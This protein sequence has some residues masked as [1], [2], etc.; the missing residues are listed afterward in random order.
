M[1]ARKLVAALLGAAALLPGARAAPP[2][3]EAFA[4]VPSMSGV[5]ISPDG[6]RIAYLRPVN[7]LPAAFVYDFDSKAPPVAV[8]ASDPTLA[9]IAW[10]RF[11][12]DTV[13]VCGYHGTVRSLDGPFPA[14]RLVAVNLADRKMKVLI[15]RN[16]DVGSSQFQDEILDW[17]AGDPTRVL[18]ALR[19]QFDEHPGVYDLDV[20]TGVLHLRLQPY[21]P[22]DEFT[23]DATGEVRLGCGVRDTSMQCFTRDPADGAWRLLVKYEYFLGEG[24]RLAK[25]LGFGTD[26]NILYTLGEF[27]GHD[28]LWRVDLRDRE[29]PQ[30][31]FTHPLV[32][33]EGTIRTRSGRL[34]G[35]RY[36]TDRPNVYYLDDAYRDEMRAVAALV[37]DHA[38]EV[39]SASADEARHI[40]L[41]RSD[42]DAGSYYLYDRGKHTLLALGREYPELEPQQL[43]RMQW[44]EYA[45][46]D[47]T[48]IPGY[49][50][51]PRGAPAK[52]L[53]LIVM[54]HGGPI[55]RDRWRFFFLQ[56]FLVSRGYAVLQ[57]NFRGSAGYGSAWFAAAHQDWGGL[58]YRDIEDGARWAVSSGVADPGR[59]AVVGW[60]FGGYAAL[61]AAVR[62]G[63]SYRGAISI[64]G[65]SDLSELREEQHRFMNYRIADRQIGDDRA[66]LKAD[67]P[68][69]HAADAATPVLLIHGTRDWQ[70][71]VDHSKRM[72]S[73]LKS[74][75]K[76][77]E[78]ILLEGE[79]HQIDGEAARAALLKAVERFLLEH[80]GPGVSPPT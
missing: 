65:V 27:E 57:M 26:P 69:R 38:V 1:M 59:M 44:I 37:P 32:D 6:R 76:P 45:A 70:V 48:K 30:L 34:L 63:A 16:R 62:D 60:S 15:E 33:V 77:V 36:D 66:K 75:K 43:G 2:P 8:L 71:E 13:L 29:P 51:V 21:R 47:G 19:E 55:A 79:S 58:T 64:A 74:A 41:A 54:P 78:L 80:L 28:A 14:S 52:H 7:G 72:N 10:C 17:Q 25:P 3:V 9:K 5:R 35:V 40:V 31:E 4:H 67:S 50:T 56:Q 22:I 61:L 46:R 11:K 12:N 53:P 20:T 18:V 73:A 23:T 24:G 68:A 39:V 42:V 49:L